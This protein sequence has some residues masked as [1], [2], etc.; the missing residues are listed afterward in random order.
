MT[1]PYFILMIVLAIVANLLWY[2]MK[3]ILSE[4]NYKVNFWHGH[5]KDIP[6]FKNLINQT[7]N[8]TQKKKYNKIFWSLITSLLLFIGLAF[9][10][11]INLKN[12]L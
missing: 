6:N 4:N 2:T 10:C 7:E 1:E 12:L 11:I 8:Q 9:C 3:S 5:L